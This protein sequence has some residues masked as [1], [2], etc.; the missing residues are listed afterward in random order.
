MWRPVAN[1]CVP[2]SGAG[3]GVLY[4]ELY[5]VGGDNGSNILSSVEKYKPSRGVWTTV[6]S[7]VFPRKYAGNCK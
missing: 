2:R 4:G 6:A 1:M 5:A 3:V 7:I